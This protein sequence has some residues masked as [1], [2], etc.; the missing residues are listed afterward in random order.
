M[1]RGGDIGTNKKERLLVLC[2]S[3]RKGPSNW[4]NIWKNQCSA[5]F[6]LVSIWKKIYALR[7]TH[8]PIYLL[9][10]ILFSSKMATKIITHPHQWADS[11]MK[12]FKKKMAN[13]VF[14]GGC[15]IILRKYMTDEWWQH[16]SAR[17]ITGTKIFTVVF[18]QQPPKENKISKE[19][20]CPMTRSVRTYIGFLAY[21]VSC[22][23]CM[24]FQDAS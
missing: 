21:L 4:S 12:A 11:I 16:R 23:V 24:R 10:W 19:I 13:N 7:R 22:G 6:S 3:Q 18:V 5:S 14:C 17:S 20:A 8:D 1:Y 15:D 9:S 2:F